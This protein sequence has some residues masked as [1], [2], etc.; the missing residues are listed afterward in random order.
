MHPAKI[1]ISLRIRAV[2]SEFSLCAVSKAKDTKFLHAD[3]ADSDQTARTR[4]LIWVF[5]RRTCKKGRF[6]NLRLQ[7]ILG[8]MKIF[9]LSEANLSEAAFLADL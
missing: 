6:L 1:Q 4:R 5:V 8:V 7:M 9:I 3:N 2:W